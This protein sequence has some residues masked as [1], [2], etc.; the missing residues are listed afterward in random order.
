MKIGR[1][2]EKVTEAQAI[3]NLIKAVEYTTKRWRKGPYNTK[4]DWLR[5]PLIQI[6][7][8]RAK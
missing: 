5:V 2:I 3:E 6:R 7:Q 1:N 4:I 8:A